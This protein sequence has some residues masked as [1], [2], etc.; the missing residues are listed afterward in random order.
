MFLGFSIVDLITVS[1][2]CE[3]MFWLK[4]Y[5]L[6]LILFMSIGIFA[7]LPYWEWEIFC[8]FFI[9]SLS[10]FPQ[11]SSF[12]TGTLSHQNHDWFG[13]LDF[14]PCAS[15]LVF[16]LLAFAQLLGPRLYFSL[17]SYLLLGWS[18]V[19]GGTVSVYLHLDRKILNA[20][21]YTG[22]RIL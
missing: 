10:P 11:F 8:F 4:M 14:L 9:F 2:D 3:M 12:V 16:M 5:V 1:F 22:Y 15:L 17:S 21:D 6:A 20:I 7:L 19:K 13:R 18:V